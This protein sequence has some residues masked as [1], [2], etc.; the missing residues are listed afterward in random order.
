MAK[1][2][3]PKTSKFIFPKSLTGILG[4]DDITSGGLPKNRPTLLLGNTGCG[5]IIM[6]MES[7]VNGIVLFNEPAVFMAFEEKTGEL[8][9][10]VKSFGFDLTKHIAENKL[11]LQHVENVMDWKSM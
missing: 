5:K 10:N 9:M 7:L 8:I 4:L 11:H 3:N 6:A 1:A 2:H